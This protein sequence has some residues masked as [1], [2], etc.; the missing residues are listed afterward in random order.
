MKLFQA[1][2]RVSWSCCQH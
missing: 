1:V 2:R